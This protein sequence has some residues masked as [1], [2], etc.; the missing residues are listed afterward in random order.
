M[1]SP[2][3]TLG[4][5]RRTGDGHCSKNTQL[6]EVALRAIRIELA[7]VLS[8]AFRGLLMLM[9]VMPHM[10]GLRCTRLVLAIR[11]HRCVGH[12]QRY[13]QEKQKGQNSTHDPHYIV[14]LAFVLN[15]SSV[16]SLRSMEGAALE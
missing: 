9:G 14:S 1:A 6:H 7:R 16:D 10:A 11:G 12:L 3:L 8:V 13:D 15:L 4:F 2:Q 5:R